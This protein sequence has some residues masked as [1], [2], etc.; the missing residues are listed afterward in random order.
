L[1]WNL[2]KHGI[3][4]N[5]SSDLY[6]LRQISHKIPTTDISSAVVVG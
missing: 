3:V 2:C 4:R 5:L 1:L 6:S